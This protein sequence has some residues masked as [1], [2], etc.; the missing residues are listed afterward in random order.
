MDKI[1]ERFNIAR[2]ELL[3][4]SFKKP[5]LNYKLRATPGLEFKSLN[6]SD[7]FN[8]LVNESK[9]IG[10]TLDYVT[11]SNKL[12]VDI[13]DKELKRRLN[14]TYRQAKLYLEEKG[15]NI[16]FLTLGF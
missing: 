2:K 6:A 3:D 1:R 15:A 11:S 16:L 8:A 10:F 7:I 14:K 9:K 4:L 13:D 12:F 5:L